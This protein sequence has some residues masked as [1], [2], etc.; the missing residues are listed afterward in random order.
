[1]DSISW[2]VYHASQ[3]PKNDQSVSNI[4]LLPL[5]YKSADTV[6]MLYYAMDILVVH[7]LVNKK[8]ISLSM[9]YVTGAKL[10]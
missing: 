9:P 3:Q 8:W 4:A 1:M 7:K 6:T 5:F 2:A 10:D